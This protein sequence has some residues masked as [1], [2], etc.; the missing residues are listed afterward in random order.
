[1]AESGSSLEKKYRAAL[2]LYVGLAILSWFTLDARISVGGRLVEMKFI[3]L[4]IIGGFAL[5]TMV[6]MR[7][8]KIRREGQ[9]SRPE[10][11]KS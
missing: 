4:I 8:E 10:G 6:A 9:Q 5:R 2:V 1:M 11:L 7:A 3:P